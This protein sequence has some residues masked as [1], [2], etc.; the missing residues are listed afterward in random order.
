MRFDYTTNSGV[1]GWI[2]AENRQQAA[3]RLETQYGP[4]VIAL[5]NGAVPARTGDA[6]D[7]YGWDTAFQAAAARGQV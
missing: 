7:P 3:T 4:G 5:I 6:A 2:D 1:N